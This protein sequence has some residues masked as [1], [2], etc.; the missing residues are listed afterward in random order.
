M[1]RPLLDSP[2]GCSSPFF[3]TPTHPSAG[4]RHA[5]ACCCLAWSNSHRR[6][7]LRCARDRSRVFYQCAW[8]HAPSPPL[9]HSTTTTTHASLFPPP[10]PPAPCS[11][12]PTHAEDVM[13]IIALPPPSRRLIDRSSSGRLHAAEVGAGAQQARLRGAAAQGGRARAGTPP[14][15]GVTK[16][17]SVLS[18]GDP[19]SSLTFPLT[20]LSSSLRA[21]HPVG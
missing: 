4:W 10:T 21:V 1:S 18:F 5:A 8:S 11:T 13:T 12:D 7:A 19:S 17:S 15:P 20:I 14:I 3:P 16:L 9:H 6:A 2:V